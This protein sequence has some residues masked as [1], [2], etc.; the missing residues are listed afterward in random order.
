MLVSSESTKFAVGDRV[1][2]NEKLFPSYAEGLFD[3][4]PKTGKVVEVD[5][6]SILPYRVVID[7]F[8][9]HPF[10]FYENQLLFEDEAKEAEWQEAQKAKPKPTP[11]G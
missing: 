8:E 1:R 11:G 9:H 5:P 10:W 2:M 6:P 3:G 7:S 4:L